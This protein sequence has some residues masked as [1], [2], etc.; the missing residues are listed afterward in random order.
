MLRGSRSILRKRQGYVKLQ[1]HLFRDK[2][3][4][5]EQQISDLLRDKRKVIENWKKERGE[6]VEMIKSLETTL[7]ACVNRSEG[8]EKVID[9]LRWQLDHCKPADRRFTEEEW[10]EFKAFIEEMQNCKDSLKQ[11]ISNMNDEKKKL[12]NNKASLKKSLAQTINGLGDNIMLY[13]LQKSQLQMNLCEQ[14]FQEKCSRAN[15]NPSASI[16]SSS[17][18]WSYGSSTIGSSVNKLSLDFD[19]PQNRIMRSLFDEH[20][21]SPQKPLQDS[22]CMKHTCSPCRKGDRL[23]VCKR[24]LGRHRSNTKENPTSW[25]QFG[26]LA[27]V[28]RPAQST[29]TRRSKRNNHKVAKSLEKQNKEQ[30]HG[31]ARRIRKNSSEAGC[32]KLW[33]QHLRDAKNYQYS[34]EEKRAPK[35]KYESKERWLFD[36]IIDYLLERVQGQRT[37]I[38]K[39]QTTLQNDTRTGRWEGSASK[40][41]MWMLRCDLKASRAKIES[42]KKELSEVKHDNLRG[43]LDSGFKIQLQNLEKEITTLCDLLHNVLNVAGKSK[44]K[45]KWD[46]QFANVRRKQSHLRADNTSS[47]DSIFE[48]A[49]QLLYC[50]L[51]RASPEDAER[52]V[53]IIADFIWANITKLLGSEEKAIAYQEA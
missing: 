15:S 53:T 24:L 42:L 28:S 17:R 19:N 39:L 32:L 31:T 33:L 44:D 29:P 10:I 41:L 3:T 48:N 47:I 52:T 12:R 14:Q 4:C 18:K 50:C 23:S 45:S 16:T 46:A 27:P 13:N 38:E 37:E 5:L 2:V 11:T 36:N 20:K 21:T 25:R 8:Q 34:R 51:E 49:L 26:G 43:A 6:M 9:E 1:K 7:E 22:D 35:R 40:K 30:K